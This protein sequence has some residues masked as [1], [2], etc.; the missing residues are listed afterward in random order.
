MKLYLVCCNLV[1][2]YF[3][4]RYFA[5]FAIE[6]D[7]VMCLSLFPANTLTLSYSSR[8]TNPSFTKKKKFQRLWNALQVGVH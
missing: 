2:E 7:S 5:A 1:I 4:L 3:T 6:C 8:K